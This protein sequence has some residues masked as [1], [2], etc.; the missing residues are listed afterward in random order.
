[1]LGDLSPEEIETLLRTEFTARIGCHA[2]GRTYVVPVTYAY[3]A[4]SVYG[5]STKGLKIQMMRKNPEVCFEVDRVED[6]GNWKSVIAWGRFEELGG[7]KALAAMD[8][9]I[10]RLTPLAPKLDLHPS[11]VLRAAEAESSKVDGRGVVLY[12]IRLTERTGRFERA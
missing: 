4:D 10:A 12:R 6:I 11:Y 1:M 8:V 7:S 9:L 3:E 5:H 2:E